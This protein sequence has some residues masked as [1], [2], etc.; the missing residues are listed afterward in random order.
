[1]AIVPD[2]FIHE[3]ASIAGL[4]LL[5]FLGTFTS[6]DWGTDV[7]TNQQFRAARWNRAT[8]LIVQCATNLQQSDVKLFYFTDV[9]NVVEWYTIEQGFLKYNTTDMD[10]SIGGINLLS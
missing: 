9:G 8:A 7:E 4:D 10:D 2:F 6:K 1:M 5:V 3:Y